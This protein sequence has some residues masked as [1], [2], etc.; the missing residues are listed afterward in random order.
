MESLETVELANGVTRQGDYVRVPHQHPMGMLGHQ[1][2][3]PHGDA[4]IFLIAE[5]DEAQREML[6]ITPAP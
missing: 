4:N 2:F 5:L 1:R 3:A 6:G